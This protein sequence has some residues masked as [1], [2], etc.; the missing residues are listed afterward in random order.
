MKKASTSLFKTLRWSESIV[1]RSDWEGSKYWR[2]HLQLNSCHTQDPISLLL[3]L[4]GNVLKQAKWYRKG[5]FKNQ[6]PLSLYEK[7]TFEGVPLLG[8][9]PWSP[10]TESRCWILLYDAVFANNVKLLFK[11]SSDNI[12]IWRKRKS[13]HLTVVSFSSV[14]I[15]RQISAMVQ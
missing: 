4:L 15:K 11:V 13:P 5:V 7:Q 9:S 14:P 8:L 2:L 6:M 3:H 1:K 10:S 12:V